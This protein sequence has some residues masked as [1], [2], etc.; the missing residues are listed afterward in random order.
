M[1]EVTAIHRFLVRS[2]L[3]GTLAALSACATYSAHPLETRAAAKTSLAD[4][5]HAAALPDRLGIADVERLALDNN[6]ELIAARAQHGLSQA[7]LRSAGILPNPV[8][9]AS[10]QDV[11]SGPGMFAALAAGLSQDLKSLVTL[12]SKRHAA[13]K[14]AQS[15][16]ATIL[17]QEWQTVGKA[18]LSAVDLIE[19]DKQLALLGGNATL[20]RER[21]ERGREALAQ[22]DTTLTILAPDLAAASDAQKLFDDFERQQQTRRRDLNLLLGLAPQVKLDLA[23]AADV[24]ALDIKAIQ[25]QLPD[26]ANRRPDLIALQLGYQAQEEKVR[27]AILA[28]FPLFSLGYAYGRDTSNV[29]SLGPQLTMDLPLFDRNQGNIALERATRAQLHA[30]FS[31]RLIAAKSEVDALIADQQLLQRQLD[32][33]RKLLAEMEPVA[34]RAQA[35]YR[36]ADIDERSYVDLM[37]MRNAKRQEILA[38][39]LTLL[40]QQVAIATLVGSG[41][42][43]VA[44]AD[45]QNDSETQP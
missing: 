2:A 22:G 25:A 38:L 9:N 13:Q 45:A 16:D 19:G 20:W 40:E 37:T 7:Q 23:D 39:E 18:R 4:L 43:P 26:L 32:A 1:F 14:S 24:P 27:G 8:F 31:A 41:M 29:R 36:N 10:Y 3:A 12:S 6:P 15:V 33:K 21:I 5:Q 34:T 44:L 28:Q 11:L 42:P 17:W 35:A 30:E